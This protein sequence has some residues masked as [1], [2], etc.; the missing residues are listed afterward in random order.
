MMVCGVTMNRKE[1]IGE[2]FEIAFGCSAIDRDFQ[3]EEVL[4]ELRKF[5]NNS[6]KYEEIEDEF[7]QNNPDGRKWVN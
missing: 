4:E 7:W 5:S 2:V 3:Y 1:F 6:L